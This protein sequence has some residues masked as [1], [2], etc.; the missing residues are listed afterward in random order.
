MTIR[1][2]GFD[3]SDNVHTPHR[4]WP[5]GG[6]NIERCWRNMNV[7]GIS[8]A[9]V[10]FSSM[11]MTITFHGRPVISYPEG[12]SWSWYARECVYRTFLHEFPSSGIE[13]QLGPHILTVLSQSSFYREFPRLERNPLL[14]SEWFSYHY[15]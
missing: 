3:G 10:T 8:L 14:S 6:Q 4:E 12:F 5:G 1:C 15:Q 13:P 9:L 11:L 2:F 7:I